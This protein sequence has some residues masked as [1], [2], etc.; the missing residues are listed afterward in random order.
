MLAALDRLKISD[1]N[2]QTFQERIA[3]LEKANREMMQENQQLK[4]KVCHFFAFR[5]GVSL[6]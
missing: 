6:S 5:L 2:A 4:L 1:V 3:E